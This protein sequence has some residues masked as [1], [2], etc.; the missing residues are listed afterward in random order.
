MDENNDT[1]IKPVIGR[2]ILVPANDV[3]QTRPI[4]ST[5]PPSPIGDSNHIISDSIP[6]KPIKNG[7]SMSKNNSF[8]DDLR[9]LH[10]SLINN[11]KVNQTKVQQQPDVAKTPKKNTSNSNVE[12]QTNKNSETKGNFFFKLPQNPPP[13][14]GNIHCL[15]WNNQ[16][17][18]DL[19]EASGSAA[20]YVRHNN[21]HL[22]GA[23]VWIGT[24]ASGADEKVGVNPAS[25]VTGLI[26][27]AVK[28]IAEMVK[29]SSNLSS[30]SNGIDDQGRPY[31]FA[32]IAIIGGQD[33]ASIERHMDDMNMNRNYGEAFKSLGIQG[34]ALRAALYNQMGRLFALEVTFTNKETFG[35]GR[36]LIFLHP[37]NDIGGGKSDESL[38]DGRLSSQVTSLSHEFDW[39]IAGLERGGG[40]IGAIE[41]TLG[42]TARIGRYA[43]LSARLPRTLVAA[44]AC[45]IINID[46]A[47]WVRENLSSQ[48]DEY[49]INFATT[50]LRTVWGKVGE[51]LNGFPVVLVDRHD[52]SMVSVRRMRAVIAIM[53]HMFL[54][55]PQLELLRGDISDERIAIQREEAITHSNSMAIT[56]QNENKK[57]RF[58]ATQQRR[59]RLSTCLNITPSKI[60]KLARNEDP[61]LAID[62]AE[63]TLEKLHSLVTSKKDALPSV[64]FTVIDA[65]VPYH[66]LKSENNAVTPQTVERAMETI[67]SGFKSQGI[68][69]LLLNLY[70]LPEGLGESLDEVIVQI[71][72]DQPGVNVL[73]CSTAE[74]EI[75]HQRVIMKNPQLESISVHGTVTVKGFARHLGRMVDAHL[76]SK[77]HH[78]EDDGRMIHQFYRTYFRGNY[79]HQPDLVLGGFNRRRDNNKTRGE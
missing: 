55:N 33:H 20:D 10:L 61:S 27:Q 26:P 9:A 42:G 31:Q 66:I 21:W 15:K 8:K 40:K 51:R 78:C 45:E 32:V 48:I 75:H 54:G 4:V 22:N 68:H 14:G 70:I 13:V 35:H 62:D 18:F 56:D 29:T 12:N 57:Q 24:T 41:S 63:A 30:S 65:L 73:M 49:R 74:S 53:R 76:E 50:M 47:D 43:L 25:G 1:Q 52:R 72:D 69:K 34:I 17:N 19:I 5:N 37:A 58:E 39:W 77:Y 59:V 46:R 44:D 11:Q 2:R 23:S 71:S 7:D 16:S 38:K 60:M 28:H 67:V 6:N 36:H 3:M 79:G 64:F